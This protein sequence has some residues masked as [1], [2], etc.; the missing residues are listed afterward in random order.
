MKKF[1]GKVI[2]FILLILIFSALFYWFQIRPARI[3]HDCSWIK[4]HVDKVPAKPGKTPQQI[5]ADSG[6]SLEDQQR[7]IK[8][9]KGEI[10]PKK[11]I[12]NSDLSNPVDTL[13]QN[14]DTMALKDI[15]GRLIN[16]IPAEKEVP[17]FDYP[18]EAT[19]KEYTFCLHSK[20]L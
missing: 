3:K 9:A 5:A 13:K 4:T 12:G 2:M 18:R 15:G 14:L 8:I 10:D 11:E 16:G 7:A 19:P 17:A 6:L 20:G 1:V